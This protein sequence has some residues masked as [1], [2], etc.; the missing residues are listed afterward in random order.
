MYCR[1]PNPLAA[2]LFA[3]ALI[4]GGSACSSDGGS[5]EPVSTTSGADVA[6][7]EAAGGGSEG[8]DGDEGDGQEL[9]IDQSTWA[10]ALAAGTSADDHLVEGS[11][12]VLIFDSGS[13]DD[14][15]ATVNCSAASAI[16]PSTAGEIVLRYPDGSLSCADF[17]QGGDS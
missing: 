16:A 1:P 14:V 9:D 10:I 13:K 12:I 3:L 6:A 8:T 17:N 7:D 11:T 15:K 4:I 5:A 2:A